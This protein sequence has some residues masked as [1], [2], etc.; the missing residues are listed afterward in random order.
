MPSI[1][2]HCQNIFP[3]V[4]TDKI[5]YQESIKIYRLSTKEPPKNKRV[6]IKIPVFTKFTLLFGSDPWRGML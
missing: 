4:R 2:S 5:V 6:L 3:N 1:S